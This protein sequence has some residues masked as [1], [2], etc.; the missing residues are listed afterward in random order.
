MTAA[1]VPTAADA[2]RAADAI[3]ADHAEIEGVVLFG[4]VADGAAT[5]RS[6]IDLL[7]IVD[8][9]DCSASDFSRLQDALQD[10]VH[11][12]TGFNCDAIAVTPRQLAWSVK[13]ARSSVYSQAVRQGRVLRG[14]SAANGTCGD[15]A[16][17]EGDAWTMARNDRKLAID[18]ILQ[19]VRNGESVCDAAIRHRSAVSAG[20]RL[21]ALQ[22][23]LEASHACIEACLNALGRLRKGRI[24][25][26]DHKL[27]TMLEELADEPVVFAA[28]SA[29][30]SALPRDGRGR[31][32]VWR[33][34]LYAGATEDML[35]QTTGQNAAAHMEAAARLLEYAATEARAPLGRLQPIT[36]AQSAELEDADEVA[37]SLHAA[38]SAPLQAH[39]AVAPPGDSRPLEPTH[40]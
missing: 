28:A 11:D 9:P 1:A 14:R 8:T 31:F 27:E 33:R 4:S 20:R 13:Y 21:R 37:A 10:R 29:A 12:V 34:A 18:D 39:P 5:E 32:T 24:L 38:A 35:A 3:R 40:R 15:V 36:P 30:L 25:D 16:E 22:D 26:R 19:A 2:E 6:D 23:A 7:V 17:I